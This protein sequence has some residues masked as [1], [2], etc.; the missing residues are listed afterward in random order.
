MCRALSL[1]MLHTPPLLRL[2]RF[3]HWLICA[4]LR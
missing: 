2:L 1:S 3:F 4:G